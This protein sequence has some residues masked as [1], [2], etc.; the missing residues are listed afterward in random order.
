[1][2]K[3]KV[4][5]TKCASSHCTEPEPIPPKIVATTETGS[6]SIPSMISQP[7]SGRA[8]FL[9]DTVNRRLIR[10][11]RNA[12]PCKIVA[13]RKMLTPKISGLCAAMTRNRTDRVHRYETSV[14]FFS[15]ASSVSASLGIMWKL[16]EIIS[17]PT[18][19]YRVA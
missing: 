9:S 16:L 15:L 18:A 1:M 5:L 6:A 10:T 2:A 8:D 12:N 17:I 19:P 4:P 14:P 7:G 13:I 11:A 3:K